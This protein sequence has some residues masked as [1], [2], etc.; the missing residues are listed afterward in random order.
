MRNKKTIIIP[1]KELIKNW[2]NDPFK[3]YSDNYSNDEYVNGDYEYISI[4]ERLN[5]DD[6]SKS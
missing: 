3:K 2:F 6:K 1:S 4:E 5:N